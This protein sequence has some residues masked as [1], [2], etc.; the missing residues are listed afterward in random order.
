MPLTVFWPELDKPKP[1]L[2]S[3]AGGSG[4]EVCHKSWAVNGRAGE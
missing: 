3:S 2:P 4:R 1:L